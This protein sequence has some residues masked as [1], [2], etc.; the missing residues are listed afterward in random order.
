MSKLL[1]QKIPLLLG[2]IESVSKKIPINVENHQDIGSRLREELRQVI[3][4]KKIAI[5][6]LQ[7]LFPTGR[8]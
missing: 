6:I 1:K 4:D 2:L 8:K 5:Q 7:S 3:N